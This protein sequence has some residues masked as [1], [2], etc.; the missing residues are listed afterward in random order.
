VKDGNGKVSHMIFS[1]S[2]SDYRANKAQTD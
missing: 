2:G 1:I